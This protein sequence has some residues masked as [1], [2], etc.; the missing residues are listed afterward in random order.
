MIIKFFNNDFA[1]FLIMIIPLNVIRQSLLDGQKP[2]YYN[3][4]YKNALLHGTKKSLLIM[5]LPF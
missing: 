5:I 1:L 2:R 3:N 4:S